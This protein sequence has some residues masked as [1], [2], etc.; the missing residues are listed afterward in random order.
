VIV[1]DAS[2]YLSRVMADESD[3]YSEHVFSTIQKTAIAMMVPSHFFIEV[4]NAC[5]QSY[6]RGRISR[7]LLLSYV[8]MLNN[9]PPLIK[10]LLKAGACLVLAE[11]YSL[12]MYDAAYLELAIRENAKIATLDKPLIKA[13]MQEKVYFT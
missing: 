6:R 4:Y 11:R 9:F 3:P 8:R 7:E 1:I 2:V 13:A 12:S 5:F 10:P